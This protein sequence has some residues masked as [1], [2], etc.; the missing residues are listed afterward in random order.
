MGGMIAKSLNKIIKRLGNLVKRKYSYQ[1]KIRIFSANYPSRIFFAQE[2]NDK[3][4]RQTGGTAPFFVSR[5]GNVELGAIRFYLKNRRRARKRPYP[6]QVKQAM[7]NNAGFFP[8][9]DDGLDAFCAI[10][11]DAMR[12]ISA[13]GVWFNDHEWDMANDYCPTALLVELECLN[14]FLYASPY[15]SPL[16]GKNVLVIHPFT[17]T[18]RH[19]YDTKRERLFRDPLVLPD[20]NLSLLKS[21][22]TI[23]GNT[24]GYSSWFEAYEDMCER[25]NGME[26]DI[27]IIGAGAYGLPL[28]ARA[29]RKGKSVLHLGGATQL[30]FGIKGRRWEKEYDFAEKVF[31]EHWVY[32]AENER[33][34]NFHNIENGCYW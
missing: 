33:P 18:I 32:P 10:Y 25:I 16:E 19:Q 31:N 34:P 9:T 28:G 11:L 2:G 1:D 13:L 26:F 29:R 24:D 22:Q 12:D 8:A 14:S 6:E 7:F 5:F 21:P 20:F 17:E 4:L 3:L 23:A 30:L 15:T 27:A